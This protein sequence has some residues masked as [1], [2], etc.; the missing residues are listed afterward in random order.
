VGN[1]SIKFG[2]IRRW[3]G[4]A[5]VAVALQVPAPLLADD[6]V[7]DLPS[8]VG[9]V[10]E[11]AGELFLATQDRANEWAPIG[12]NYPITTG[13]NLWVS[14]DGR[15]EIDFGAGQFR[16]AGD[17][18]LQLSALDDRQLVLFVA[19]GRAIIR[20]RALDPGE[21]V[22]IDTPQ[23]Q[24]EIDRPGQYRVDV[25]P[26]LQQTTLTVREGEAGIR[27]AGG[28]QQTLPGQA[29]TISGVDGANIAIQNGFGGDGFDA[30]S[31]ARDLR[32]DSARGP[33]YVSREMV[34]AR[35]LDDYGTWETSPTYGP[36]WYPATVAVGW[37]PYRFGNWTWVAPWGLTWVDAAPW[38]YAPFH[39]GRW[40]WFS[41]RWGWCPGRFVARPVWAPALVGWYGGQ[42]WTS[43]GGAVYGWVPLG[44]G[45]PFLPSWSRCSAR[46]WRQHNLPYAV[47]LADRPASPPI[48]YANANV[49][50]ALT[51]VSSSVLAGARPVAANLVSIPVSAGA[52]APVL[53]GAPAV[54][55]VPGRSL[56]RPVIAAPMPA[57]TQY[58]ALS[59][60]HAPRPVTSVASPGPVLPQGVP[61]NTVPARRAAAPLA[62]TPGNGGTTIS[63]PPAREL[64]PVTPPPSPP[65]AVPQVYGG[66]S[67]SRGA[68][69]GVA[70]TP[71]PKAPVVADRGIPLPPS[72]QLVAPG[73]APVTVP[74]APAAQQGGH[75]VPQEHGAHP[76]P[77]AKEAPAAANVVNVG[78]PPVPK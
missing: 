9:R 61:S 12:L 75:R 44:W 25:V 39:Y 76:A 59:R 58:P 27:F 71:G 48:R 2:A 77:L 36:V 13:D 4:A 11:T 42:G 14:A 29:V 5:L 19:S 6:E 30:W 20:L 70:P 60:S 21:I 28:V 78:A 64:R 15:A 67:G 26:E 51:A 69:T 35:E 43:A 32:Y 53:A 10:S 46:C 65:S 68:Y 41:G 22:R 57:G 31:A 73:I 56:P 49:P 74:Q 18:N 1:C 63:T 54:R 17:T 40:V 62:A 34:G 8:R 23:T 47:A 66:V 52:V 45:E 33:A 72:L 37:A 55:P 16:M 38:G 50:G 7:A 24:I 3:I